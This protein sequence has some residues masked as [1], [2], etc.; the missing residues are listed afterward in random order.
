MTKIVDSIPKQES[1]FQLGNLK[2]A[3]TCR[4]YNQDTQP[5][6][7]LVYVVNTQQLTLTN[8]NTIPTIPRTVKEKTPH[9]I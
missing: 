6:R 4:E 3:H 7:K 2:D 1:F 5:E 9:Q 8:D